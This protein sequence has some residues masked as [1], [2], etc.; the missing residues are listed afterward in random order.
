MTQARQSTFLTFRGN[1]LLSES[2]Q[3]IKGLKWWHPL[4]RTLTSAMKNRNLT[5]EGLR[6]KFST[7]NLVSLI[8]SSKT[9]LWKHW[10]TLL[11]VR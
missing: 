8:K 6:P 4:T 5:E 9:R 10:G 2:S 1:A 11:K 3:S 7:T